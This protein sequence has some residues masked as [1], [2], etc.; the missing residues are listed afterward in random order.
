MGSHRRLCR[1]HLGPF[2]ALFGA[3]ST[4]SPFHT[5]LHFGKTLFPGTASPPPPPPPSSFFAFCGT[6]G[7]GGPPRSHHPTGDG[8]PHGKKSYARRPSMASKARRG[9]RATD[10]P[11]FPHH[12]SRLRTFPFLR[13][14]RLLLLL[15]AS[16]ALLSGHSVAL[17]SPIHLLLTRGWGRGGPV[18][19]LWQSRAYRQHRSDGSTTLCPTP[20]HIAFYFHVDPIA[21]RTCLSIVGI[22]HV[23][24]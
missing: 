12:P 10:G 17:L 20:S 23:C 4:C 16:S 22:A 3:P 1:P 6:R 19:F 21:C 8:R 11:T 7:G 14:L 15:P 9:A 5:L 2:A 18:G 24:D 13:L